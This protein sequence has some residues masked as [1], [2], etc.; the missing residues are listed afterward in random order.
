[1]TA[2]ITQAGAPSRAAFRPRFDT[3]PAALMIVLPLALLMSWPR[4]VTVWQTG[5]YFDSDDAMR[6]VEVRAWLAGQGWYDLVAHRLVPPAGL[7]MHWSRVVDVP[8]GLLVRLFGL[9]ADPIHAERLARLAFPLALQ[10]AMIA[11]TAW[12]ARLLAGPGA[13]LPAALLIVLSGIAFGQF[14]PG[15]VDHHAPQ[16]LLLMLSTGTTLLSLDPSR[17]RFAALTGALIALS[18]AISLENLP[19]FAVLLAVPPVAWAVGG[20]RYRRVLVRFA[21]GLGLVLPPT[22]MLTVAPARWTIV[23]SD[24]LSIAHVAALGAGVLALL[25]LAGLTPRL[26]ATRWRWFATSLM[27]AAVLVLVAAA[28]PSILHGPYAAMDPLIEGMWLSHVQEAQPIVRVLRDQPGLLPLVLGPLLAGAVTTA[29]VAWSSRGPARGRWLV[30][31]ALIATGCAGAAWEFR[32]T[33]SVTPLALLGGA[34]VV[35]RTIDLA[36]RSRPLYLLLPCGSILLFSSVAWA[37]VPVPKSA[38][39]GAEEIAAAAACRDGASFAPLALYPAITAFA[40]IDVGSY[41]LADTRMSAI[42]APYHRNQA[43][44]LLVLKAFMA[45]PE[46]AK[47][48]IRNSVANVVLIC[49]GDPQLAIAAKH[50][51]EGLA[52]ALLDGRVPDWLVPLPLAG[53]PYRAYALVRAG[54]PICPKFRKTRP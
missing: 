15:R 48:M 3:V 14:Q 25:I 17:A 18:L 11:A 44:N 50:A 24:A 7:L 39:P 42:G 22:F 12:V 37:M 34:A 8:L 6:M 54:G 32:V 35:A 49:P 46:V 45:D 16:I 23:T 4:A 41:I 51:P 38:A 40:P 33:G 10:V 9:V 47:A 52:A 29:A 21:L 31:V 5:A 27:G 28:Y 36:R 1:M 20:E 53:T 19:F 26:P 13:V 30:V 2:F 43:G